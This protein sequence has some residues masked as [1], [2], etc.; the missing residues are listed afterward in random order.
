MRQAGGLCIIGTERHES[1]RIDNQ[2]R[3]RA[4]RQ[5]D[6]GESRFYIS[7][8]DDLMRLFGSDRISGMLDKLG[9]D[10]DTP[11]DQKILSNAIES[12]QSKVEGRNFQSRKYTLD[13]DD[14]MNRQREIIYDQRR[15][16]LDGENLKSSIQA[17]IRD[18]VA[19]SVQ[20]MLGEHNYLDTWQAEEIVKRW[21]KVFL[22]PGEMTFTP[23]DLDKLTPKELIEQLQEKA[24]AVYEAKEQQLGEQLMRELERVI[25]LKV[26][27]THWMDHIDAMHELRRGIGLQAYAQQDPVVAYKRE[28]FDMFDEMINEIKDDTARTIFIARVVGQNAPQREQ[29]MKPT[30]TAGAD[31]G[32]RTK[33]PV[34]SG[35]KPGRND[36][37]PCGSG[38]KYKKCC[39]KNE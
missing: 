4:G 29:M 28:G 13:Y 27:D 34:R 2:L 25:L 17:M 3:G 7:L 39:G 24:M 31:D 38:L 33:Q 36:P 23:E 14:V 16:V 18:S 15:K 12:A 22:Q 1:R 9:L 32:S 19:R 6:P 20:S 21:E 5:G 26:V 11:I 37:C 8:E 10:D 30:A 35:K